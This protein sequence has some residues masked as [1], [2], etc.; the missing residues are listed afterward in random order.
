MNADCMAVQCFIG[1]DGQLQS[2]KN[3]SK[4][5][6]EGN[7]LGIPTMGVTAVGKD[8]E[9][10]PK[11]FRLATRM[12]AELGAQIVKCYYCDDFETVTASCP[13]PIVTA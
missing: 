8:M 2:L 6:N 10:T 7:R 13:F 4:S 12:I 3:L 9:R 5:I 11:Y 1:A